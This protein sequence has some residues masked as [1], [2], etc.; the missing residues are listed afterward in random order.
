MCIYNNKYVWDYKPLIFKDR[1]N[2]ASTSFGW[3]WNTTKH[4]LTHT[5]FTRPPFCKWIQFVKIEVTYLFL[6]ESISRL[7]C[8][9]EHIESLPTGSACV[10]TNVTAGMIFIL[11]ERPP[12]HST[13]E[14]RL[15]IISDC[16]EVE[17]STEPS[18]L[19]ADDPCKHQQTL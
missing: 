5:L 9:S 6:P 19:R 11:C 16:W 12:S 7:H 15:P 1:Q 3:F 4:T 17:Q 2:I 13:Q 10:N 18:Q 14:E 8:D